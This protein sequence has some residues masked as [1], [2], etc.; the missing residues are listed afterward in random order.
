MK[1]LSWNIRQGGG[2]RIDRI[3]DAIRSHAPDAV[4]LIEYRSES[5]IELCRM[6]AERGWRYMES[7]APTGR[8]NGVCV[9]SQSPLLRRPDAPVPSESSIRWLDADLPL[10]GFGIGVLHIPGS[11]TKHN[12]AA[13]SRFWNAVLSA[14]ESRRDTPFIF[15][16]DLNTGAHRIDEVKDISLRRAL[17]AHDRC[18]RL[19]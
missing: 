2:K 18:P 4:A 8:N 19:D 14:A 7:P 15:I 10:Y 13:K 11:S 12:G 17:R 9:A 6:L 1:I 3:V 5:G 16:G